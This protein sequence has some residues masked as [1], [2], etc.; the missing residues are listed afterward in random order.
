MNIVSF[1]TGGLA[2]IPVVGLFLLI[3]EINKTYNGNSM[4]AFSK[5][6]WDDKLQK[7]FSSLVSVGVLLVLSISSGSTYLLVKGYISGDNYVNI[8]AGVFGV[9]YGGR[10][11]NHAAQSFNGIKKINSNGK[12]IK[13]KK[14]SSNNKPPIV[15]LKNILLQ[16][17][18]DKEDE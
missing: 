16:G 7:I 4:I 1:I 5:D 10:K 17:E 12:E 6:F 3:W 8:I 11:L 2:L 13:V 14:K 9:F 18:K 15:E